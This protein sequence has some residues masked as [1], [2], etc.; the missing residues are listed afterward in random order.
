MALGGCHNSCAFSSGMAFCAHD[1]PKEDAKPTEH[2]KKTRDKE[3]TR[4]YARRHPLEN[5]VFWH[6][7]RSA[8][9]SCHRVPDHFLRDE[10]KLAAGGQRVFFLA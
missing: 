9:D 8:T 4:G 10:Y 2:T 5:H 6:H 7:S 1:V 3:V